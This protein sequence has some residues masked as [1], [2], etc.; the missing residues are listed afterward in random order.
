MAS[1]KLKNRSIAPQ[2]V[3]RALKRRCRFELLLGKKV[4]VIVVTDAGQRGHVHPRVWSRGALPSCPVLQVGGLLLVG[5]QCTL[6]SCCWCD[7]PLFCVLWHGLLVWCFCICWIK[8][9]PGVWNLRLG[10]QFQEQVRDMQPHRFLQM[11]W[12]TIW[13]RWKEWQDGKDKHVEIG[14]FAHSNMNTVWIS[15]WEDFCKTSSERVE[16]VWRK[17]KVMRR[18]F[19][20]DKEIV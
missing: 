20:N 2:L 10:D 18:K 3:L 19:Q 12:C 5:V 1:V 14:R 4:F 16:K 17:E 7:H 9:G 11:M 13:K 8:D 6:C 15:S